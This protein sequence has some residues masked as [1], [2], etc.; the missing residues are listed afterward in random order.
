M[1]MVKFCGKRILELCEEKGITVNELAKIANL[2][3]I[4]IKNIIKGRVNKIRFKTMEKIIIAL[5]INFKIFFA[6]YSNKKT[7]K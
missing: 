2:N 3:P 4:T 1:N 6:N 7:I 5:N